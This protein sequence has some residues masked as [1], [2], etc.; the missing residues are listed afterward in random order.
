VVQSEDPQAA[1]ALGAWLMARLRDLVKETRADEAIPGMSRLVEEVKPQVHGDRLIL[2]LDDKQLALLAPNSQLLA[3]N[4]ARN[5]NMNRLKQITLAMWNHADAYGG[6]L[7]QWAIMSKD[8]RPLLSWRVAILPF[9][10]QGGL[11]KRFHLDEPWDSPHNRKLIPLMP[12]TYESSAALAR[13][14]KTTFLG[15]RG[16]N[17]I[18]PDD[19]GVTIREITDGTANTI[20]VVDASDKLAVPWTKPED[21]TP[22]PKKPMAGLVGHFRIGFLAGFAD[23]SAHVISKHND[24]ATLR[25]LFTRN[26]GEVIDASKY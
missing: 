2:S 3:E 8:G 16:K 4:V 14:G 7:P 6:H 18:F 20:A 15:V 1:Q 12:Q 9:I 11:Y 13:Q 22:D 23:A 21:F 10:E 17:M 24:A 25:A 19:H 26:G 5:Q